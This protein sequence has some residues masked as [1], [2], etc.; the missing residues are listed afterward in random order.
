MI[1]AVMTIPSPKTP[2]AAHQAAWGLV[3]RDDGAL[4]DFL[5][6][7]RDTGRG[8]SLIKLRS[9][10]LPAQG[11]EVEAPVA[12]GFYRFSVLVNPVRRGN[13]G[14]Y[15][16]RREGEVREWLNERMARGGM[17]VK[18]CVVEFLPSV[19]LGKPQYR[20]RIHSVEIMGIVKIVDADKAFQTLTHGIGRARS[21]G[22][23]LIEMEA[24]HG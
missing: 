15:P 20:G 13:S 23:G 1:E 3:G 11:V 2:Y 10:R 16:L 24:C 22:Y 19:E 4:R 14:E 21:M 17:D 6:R 7:V 9:R 18:S 8:V 12:G 5:F